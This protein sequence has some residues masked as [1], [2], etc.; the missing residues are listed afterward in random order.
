MGEGLHHSLQMIGERLS[1]FKLRQIAIRNCIANR[2]QHILPDMPAQL[3]EEQREPQHQMN[4]A[5][6]LEQS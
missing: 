4:V 3:V 6:N 5:A 1:N 2:H